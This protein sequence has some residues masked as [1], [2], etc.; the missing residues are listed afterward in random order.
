M[1]DTVNSLDAVRVHDRFSGNKD[2]YE[3][4]CGLSGYNMTL[5]A[6]QPGGTGITN[7]Y[8]QLYA[9]SDSWMGAAW[10]L[11]PA[12][13]TDQDYSSSCEVNCYDVNKKP[14]RGVLTSHSIHR[15]T[16]LTAP[17]A[18]G[19]YQCG[20]AYLNIQPSVS[21]KP[22][23]CQLSIEKEQWWTITVY[24]PE[25]GPRG[26]VEC[27]VVC[28]CDSGIGG[29]YDCVVPRYENL[30]KPVTTVLPPGPP[31]SSYVYPANSMSMASVIVVTVI[32]FAVLVWIFR[33]RRNP[34]ARCRPKHDM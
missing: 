22:Y 9:D 1:T 32:S 14:G 13:P 18:T 20:L 11:V 29:S 24:S 3:T 5:I 16:F 2:Q 23:G 4:F 17:S 34:A 31:D 26:S 25:D 12:K 8:C 19:Y 33:F 10:K 7:G 28:S 15:D 6:S 21:G 27:G 30:E